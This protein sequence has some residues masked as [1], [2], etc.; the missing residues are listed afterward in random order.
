DQDVYELELLL[1]DGY[2]EAL[3]IEAETLRLDKRLAAA[4]RRLGDGSVDRAHEVTSLAHELDERSGELAAL[5][6]LLAELRA[7]TESLRV[8]AV[9]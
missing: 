7:H 3:S 9:S 4:A 1:T 6:R 2:A 5:R 8:G